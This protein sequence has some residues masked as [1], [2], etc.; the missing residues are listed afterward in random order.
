MQNEKLSAGVKLG[1]G[2]CDLGG[3][4][5]FT[6]MAFWLMNYLTD[7]VGLAAGLAGAAIL[8]GKIWDAVTD[9]LMGYLS[10]RTRTRWGRRRPFILFGSIPLM[11]AMIFMFT[12]PGIENQSTLFVWAVAAFC[13]LGT[14]YTVVN[15]PYSSL[16]PELSQDFHERTSINGYRF[17]F[18]I[19][20]TLL[21]AGAVLPFVGL[22]PDRSI[23][24]SI[25]GI[26]FGGVMAVTALITFFSVREP[27]IIREKMETGF[28]S[29]YLRVFKNRPYLIVLITFAFNMTAVNVVSGILIYYFKYIY[30]NESMTTVALLILL[31]TA[32]VFIPVSVLV[33]KRVGKKAVY[34]AGLFIIA[35]ACIM[36]FFFGHTAGIPFA[37]IMMGIAGVGFATTY[38]IPWSMV[39]DTIEYDYSKTG[40]RSEGA[41]YGIWT[42]I[43]KIGNGLAIGISGGILSLTG[44]VADTVQTDTAQMGIRFIAGPIP[45]LIFA[46]GAV[47]V[48][49]YPIT[50]ER[51]KQIL[52]DAKKMDDKKMTT[53]ME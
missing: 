14:A 51:Y 42:F 34:A 49:F 38:V 16:T 9:P 1:Y 15:I 47:L 41:Y 12:N 35:F 19:F 21:G 3:N 50:E 5:Y 33:A 31:V 10:D 24:F 43:S 29:T 37:L 40:E 11:L 7:T 23:G 18:A 26:V 39:P 48:L 13:L 32:M 45:A 17:G 44:Y 46:A 22:F 36:L 52:A 2:V 8:I 4:L 20:G 25:M 6:I 53:D 27:D 28:F 30:N